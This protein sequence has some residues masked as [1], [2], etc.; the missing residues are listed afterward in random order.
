MLIFTI[1]SFAKIVVATE[2]SDIIIKKSLFT[3]VVLKV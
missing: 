3:I 2:I 1:F